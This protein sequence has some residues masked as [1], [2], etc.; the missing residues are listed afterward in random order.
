VHWNASAEYVKGKYQKL[1]L[2]RI[3]LDAAKYCYE[4][5]AFTKG[6]DLLRIALAFFDEHERWDS[7]H[8]DLSNETFEML[9]KMELSMG[10]FAACQQCNFT[11]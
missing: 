10:N 5:V 9:A 3:N 2:A 6:A 1:N 4:K 11:S 8:F 7:N